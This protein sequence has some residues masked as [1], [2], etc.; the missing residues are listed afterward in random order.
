MEIAIVDYGVGNLRSAEK[1]FQHLGFDAALTSDPAVLA[2]ARK[3]VLPGVG[4]FGECMARLS[5]Q[6]FVEPLLKE[7]RAGKP[8]LGICVG[9]QMLFENSGES[10]GVAGLGLLKGRVR[11]FSGPQ[12]SGADALKIPQIGW[13]A[14]SY[15]DA[16]RP[17]VLFSGLPSGTFMYFV[18]S[19]YAQ[20]EDAA[21][22]IAW[23]DFGGN[24]CA[25][26]GRGHIVG[27]QFH[28]EKSQ[29]AGLAMLANFAR[30]M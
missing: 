6:G 27:V 12:Y 17:H 28:P 4:A 11:K 26:V 13:N 8:L 7:V 15:P 30:L 18:H 29:R 21:D 3:I 1:A 24:F 10:P 23:S 22:V 9:M 19:Y 20:P 2:T 14:L 5:A 25:A 16:Q